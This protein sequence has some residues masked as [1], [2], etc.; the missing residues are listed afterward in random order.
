MYTINGLSF[1]TGSVFYESGI[2]N[3]LRTQYNIRYLVTL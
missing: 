3:S 1:V 2:D